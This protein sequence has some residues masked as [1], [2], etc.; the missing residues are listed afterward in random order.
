MKQM[1]C[2]K[3]D[4]CVADCR[5]KLPHERKGG[6]DV[7]CVDRLGIL[8]ATCEPY[9]DLTYP[10]RPPRGEP[11]QVRCDTAGEAGACEGCDHGRD[12]EIIPFK[13][14]TKRGPWFSCPST[15]TVVHCNPVPEPVKPHGVAFKGTPSQL[16]RYLGGLTDERFQAMMHAGI[17][18]DTAP[19]LKADALRVQ[20]DA[21]GEGVTEIGY[22]NAVYRAIRDAV[23]SS[24]DPYWRA[25]R[26][27]AR[28][29][30]LPRPLKGG[31]E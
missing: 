14:H 30:K 15:N 16:F 19:D 10:L 18:I 6:C 7:K 29:V 12:H 4:E 20:E 28:I 21:N 24:V 22:L 25:Y 17:T 5:L 9:S 8:N 3:K 26:A 1:I 2:S 13:C 23:D 11:A 31:R 27:A